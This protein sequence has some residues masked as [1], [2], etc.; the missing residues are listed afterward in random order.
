MNGRHLE[1][2]AFFAPLRRGHNLRILRR[3]SMAS[4][5]TAENLQEVHMTAGKTILVTGGAGYIGSHMVLALL[6]AGYQPVI[7]DD[8]STGHHRL[9]PSGVPVIEGNVGDSAVTA[10]LFADYDIV[11]VAHFAASI[12]VPES[13]R[14]PVKYYLNNTVSTA[15]FIASCCDAGVRHFIFSSTAAVYGNQDQNPIAETAPI[16]PENPYGHSKVMSEQILMD[17]AAAHDLTYVILRY[18]NVAGADPKGRSGQLSQ[19]ATHLIKIAVET[20]CGQRDGMQIFGTDY[21]TQDGTCI[22]DY[23]HVSDLI[24]AHVKALEHLLAG[25]GSLLANC[26]YGH[27]AS[28]RE[29]VTA[30]AQIA[31]KPIRAAEAPRRAGDA[32]MLVADS[33]RLREGLG[34]QPAHDNLSEIIADAL[35]WERSI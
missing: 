35:A 16:R 26:G 18:F 4:K 23:I 14:D 29:V 17:A 10:K 12:V 8:F 32:A 9:V 34:W 11:A 30:V 22:R 27:G 28:V 20:A 1:G 3:V 19:P 2:V 7:L 25:G 21:P 33:T 5:T 6:D 24:A 15:R 13:V 31:G